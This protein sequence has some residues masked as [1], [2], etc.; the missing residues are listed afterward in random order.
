[1]MNT[2]FFP[3]PTISTQPEEI[4]KKIADLK[5]ITF[6]LEQN[7]QSVKML[8]Q[9]LE[10]QKLTLAALDRMNI[11]PEQLSRAWCASPTQ[12]ETET[13]ASHAPFHSVHGIHGQGADPTQWWS[14]LMTQLGQAA[15]QAMSSTTNT[16]TNAQAPKDKK[17][18]PPPTQAPASTSTSRTTQGCSQKTVKK[19]EA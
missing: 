18:P 17:E 15:S 2:P 10:V 12:T 1:M 8:V 13:T 19:K 7:L 14:T 9:T 5:T 16:H 3:W 11:S 4:D 6:W